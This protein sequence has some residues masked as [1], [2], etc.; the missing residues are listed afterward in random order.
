[1]VDST[2]AQLRKEPEVIVQRETCRAIASCEVLS[3]VLDQDDGFGV[4][5]KAGVVGLRQVAA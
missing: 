5:G 3:P 4:A 1:M 2:V